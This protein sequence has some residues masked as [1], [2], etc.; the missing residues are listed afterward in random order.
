MNKENTSFHVGSDAER[1]LQTLMTRVEDVRQGME[2][3]VEEAKEDF[4]PVAEEFRELHEKHA[5]QLRSKLAEH[6]FDVEEGGSFMAKVHETVIAARSHFSHIDQN[7]L[8]SVRNGEQHVLNAFD[9][10]INK[11]E[12]DTLRDAL[13][14][15][16][17]E[18]RDCVERTRNL[19]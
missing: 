15:M 3:L 4:E 14:S 1:A 18:L 17:S 5:A 2:R 12:N 19:G 8:A 13:K 7:I 10:A 11:V 6:G 16:R 9:D